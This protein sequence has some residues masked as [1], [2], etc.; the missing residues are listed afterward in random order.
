MLL[1]DGT[2]LQN[3]VSRS[4]CGKAGTKQKTVLDDRM[5]SLGLHK[6]LEHVRKKVDETSQKN[7]D[8]SSGENI[9]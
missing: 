7:A 8:T 2:G 4:D 3:E 1:M 6:K 5:F 9:P